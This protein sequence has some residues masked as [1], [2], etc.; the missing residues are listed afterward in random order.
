MMVVVDVSEDDDDTTNKQASK[1]FKVLLKLEIL[2]IPAT[3][4]MAMKRNKY[5]NQPHNY[6]R[7]SKE[8]KIFLKIWRLCSF[9]IH[10]ISIHS[11]CSNRNRN[12]NV[13]LWR[14]LV[15]FVRLVLY[16]RSFYLVS[17]SVQ[18]T[19]CYCIELD[20]EWRHV[21]HTVHLNRIECCCW[22]TVGPT[23]MKLFFL[24][25]F[26]VVVFVVGWGR[27]TYY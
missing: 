12:E 26:V 25:I 21:S 3:T 4:T 18:S 5:N 8:T 22:R 6:I 2:K 13:F 19:E 9:C 27:V 15:S 17:Q 10:S 20:R 14:R 23:T 24:S 7:K 16:I 1:S 11:S